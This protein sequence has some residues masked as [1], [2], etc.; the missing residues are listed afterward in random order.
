MEGQYPTAVGPN[1]FYYYQPDHSDQRQHGHFTP[2]AQHPQYSG[3]VALYPE[4]LKPLPSSHMT[5]FPMAQS[6]PQTPTYPPHLRSAY[7]QLMPTP[8]ASP[9]PLH[10]RPTI[11]IDS[12]AASLHPLNT[13]CG[14][15][16]PALSLSGSSDGSPPSTCGFL[17][18]PVNGPC[19]SPE[20]LVGVKQGCEVDVLSEI[21]A[22]G[23]FQRCQ[24]PPLTPSKSC[25]IH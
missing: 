1:P 11:L 10:R 17:P 9:Q 15:A 23:D 5:H 12:Q 7:P 18:T 16:T 2:H 13:D 21:L 6:S 3:P 19:P 14:P 24:S 8:L 22:G 4:L 20:S 25:F